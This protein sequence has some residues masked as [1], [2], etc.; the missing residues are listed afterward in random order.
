M[1]VKLG[2][3]V[4]LLADLLGPLRP[5]SALQELPAGMLGLTLA[6][7]DNAKVR[8][9]QLAVRKVVALVVE[10]SGLTPP[11]KV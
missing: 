10:P 4:V 6:T 8:H 1:M 5:S 11:G 3:A 7:A 9:W 2:N